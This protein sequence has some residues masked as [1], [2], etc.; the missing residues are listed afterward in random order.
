MDLLR[1]NK[2]Y[3]IADAFGKSDTAKT[4]LKYGVKVNGRSGAIE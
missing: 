2:H 1:D 4:A 3:Y